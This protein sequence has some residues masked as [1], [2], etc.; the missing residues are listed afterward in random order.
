MHEVIQIIKQNI[1]PLQNFIFLLF[2]IL[3]HDHCLCPSLFLILCHSVVIT[4]LDMVMHNHEPEYQLS[5]QKINLLFSRS[6][7][8]KA[9]IIKI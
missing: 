6:K 5:H 8:Q 1:Y 7:L 3:T 2:I 4:K 9:L